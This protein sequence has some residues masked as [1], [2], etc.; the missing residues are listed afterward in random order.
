MVWEPETVQTQPEKPSE[1]SSGIMSEQPGRVLT[2]IGEALTRTLRWP[3]VDDA[4]ATTLLGGAGALVAVAAGSLTTVRFIGQVGTDTEGDHLLTVLTATGV[5]LRVTRAGRTGRQEVTHGPG[6]AV[7]VTQ[8][9]ATADGL[10]VIPAGHWEGSQMVYVSA[11]VLGAEPMRSTVLDVVSAAQMFGV[12]IVL[13]L[14]DADTVH[15]LGVDAVRTLLAQVGPH[16]VVADP[17]I[18]HIFGW[19]ID[20]HPSVGVHLIID[21]RPRSGEGPVASVGVWIPDVVRQD[22][23]TD[24]T[25]WAAPALAHEPD[26]REV[27][28][29]RFCVARLAGAAPGDA[30]RVAAQFAAITEGGDGLGQAAAAALSQWEL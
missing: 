29:A 28:L 17:A 19:D 3:E 20:A 27:L 10:G 7:S 12:Q 4:P 22:F 6:G 2:V 1:M 25:T 21:E 18:V 14:I 9:R 13:D 23:T 16:V 24:W 30:L 15:M 8:E 11:G 5:D 26:G